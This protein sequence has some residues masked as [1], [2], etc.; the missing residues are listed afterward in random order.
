MFPTQ[1]MRSATQRKILRV[2]AEQNK[3]YT[4]AELAEM[5][6][7]S[8]A[9]ISRA[10]TEANRYPFID[11]ENVPGS[12]ELTARLDPDSPYTAAIRDFFETERER[13]R[14]NGTVPVDIWNLLED[15]T[16]QMERKVDGFVELFLFGS[17]ATGDYYAGSD[18]DLLLLHHEQSRE[19]KETA[20][21]IVR[22]LST[23][24]EVQVIAV[25][26]N[27]E[28][29]AAADRDALRTAIYDGA[30]VQETDTLIPL[31]GEVDL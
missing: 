15:I 4:V 6:Q 21:E 18:I 29:V 5:C 23:E 24:K 7:R 16:V 28:L 25:P 27:E 10:L 1:M 12:K 26:I 30:P 14:K 9:S 11:R 31:T 2:L 22:E 3:R 19:A 13:E 20:R 17:Y 8:E